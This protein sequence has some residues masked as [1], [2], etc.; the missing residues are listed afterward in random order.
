MPGEL[1]DEGRYGRPKPSQNPRRHHLDRCSYAREV[2]LDRGAVYHLL[3][4]GLLPGRRIGR[5]W[6]ASRD[7][8][9]RALTGEQSGELE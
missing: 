6:V 4:H 1:N 2:G 8:L 3:S 5:R 9:R 7:Q